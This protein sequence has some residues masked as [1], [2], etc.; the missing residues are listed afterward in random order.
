MVRNRI[1]QLVVFLVILCM[2]I[3]ILPTNIFASEKYRYYRSLYTNKGTVRA[4]PHIWGTD[5]DLSTLKFKI[6]FKIQNNDS[7]YLELKS[8]VA[9]NVNYDNKLYFSYT[10]DS[11]V[12]SD[13]YG[14]ENCVSDDHKDFGRDLTPL[15]YL[16]FYYALKSL[17]FDNTYDIKFNSVDPDTNIVDVDFTIDYYDMQ[18]NNPDDAEC[19]L[20]GLLNRYKRNGVKPSTI[21]DIDYRLPYNYNSYR[22]NTNYFDIDLTRAD[23]NLLDCYHERLRVYLNK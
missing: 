22:I 4:A 12:D 3:G 11:S 14:C 9:S 13:G 10:G 8:N 7:T 18:S 6:N 19:I 23:Y 1:K 5:N 21:D 2:F 17:D 20:S 15:E 16:N